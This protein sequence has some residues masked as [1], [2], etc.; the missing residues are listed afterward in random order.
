MSYGTDDHKARA[1]AWFKDLRDRICAAFE[2]LEDEL[3]GLGLDAAIEPNGNA[4]MKR[5]PR[6]AAG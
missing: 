5:W 3:L 4:R 2:Q 6:L 1:S